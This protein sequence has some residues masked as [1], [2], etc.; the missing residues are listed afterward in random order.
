MARGLDG[1]GPARVP[2]RS[3][4]WHQAWLE[5]RSCASPAQVDTSPTFTA[6][7]FLGELDTAAEAARARDVRDVGV[8]IFGGAPVQSSAYSP[9]RGMLEP[10]HRRAQTGARSGVRASSRRYRHERGYASPTAS[11]P[12]DIIA[13][14]AAPPSRDSSERREGPGRRESPHAEARRPDALLDRH[15][16]RPSAT[17]CSTRSRAAAQ[18]YAQPR[19]P[20]AAGPWASSSRSAIARTP[21]IRLARVAR[22]KAREARPQGRL[23]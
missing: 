1:R 8:W 7:R 18:A 19:A 20:R 9:L 4:N 12:A 16:E 22:S 15:R 17:S 3:T 5:E 10:V 6:P 23:L 13:I 11:S 2:K 14:G 21:A